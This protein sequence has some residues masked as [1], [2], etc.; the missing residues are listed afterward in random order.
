LMKIIN[1]CGRRNDLPERDI[2]S[3]VMLQNIPNFSELPSEA[4]LKDKN[5]GYKF[6]SVWIDEYREGRDIEDFSL[7]DEDLQE[8]GFDDPQKRFDLLREIAKGR[9]NNES[10]SFA[11]IF[12][13][14][15]AIAK[16]K[17]ADPNHLNSLTIK[18]VLEAIDEA[19]CRPATLE[20]L[21]AFSQCLWK[22]DADPEELTD[23]EKLSQC[24]NS[25]FIYA[26]SSVFARSGGGRNASCLFW[27]NTERVLTGFSITLGFNNGARF[28]VLSKSRR[29]RAT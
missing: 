15:E 26:L 1:D 4:V 10:Q 19:G 27:N 14:S 17:E 29:S 21:L 3:W 20:E 9:E 8:I 24:V 7:T 23:E 28:L 6:D 2:E 22:P 12:D 11:K 13:I 18:E 5:F 16:K 25:P